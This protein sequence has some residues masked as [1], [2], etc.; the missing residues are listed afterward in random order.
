MRTEA[1]WLQWDRLSLALENQ[2]E[3]ADHDQQTD[4]KDDAYCAAQKL[5]HE[6]DSFAVG[7]LNPTG[8]W[9]E[10]SENR[11]AGRAWCAFQRLL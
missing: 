11:A 3:Q 1:P 4:Q 6:D 9:C 10:R 8:Q 2:S 7:S 5:Q